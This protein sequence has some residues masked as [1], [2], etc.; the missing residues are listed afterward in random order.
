M[1]AATAS[2]HGLSI[3]SE[4]LLAQAAAF[5]QQLQQDKAVR[6]ASEDAEQEQRRVQIREA[7]ISKQAAAAAEKEAAARIAAQAQAQR[8][9]SA[10]IGTGTGTGTAGGAT[11]AGAGAGARTGN[12]DDDDGEDEGESDNLDSERALEEAAT[13]AEKATPRKLARRKSKRYSFV[14]QTQ[15]ASRADLRKV[16]YNYGGGGKGGL[17]SGSGLGLMSASESHDSHDGGG[18]ASPSGAAS[19]SSTT[20]VDLNV[21]DAAGGGGGGGGGFINAM[22]FSSIWRLITE[23]K[24]NLFKE[25]QMFKRFDRGQEG[26]L[27]E[28]DFVE[29]WCQLAATGAGGYSGEHLLRRITALAADVT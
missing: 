18:T 19:P 27:R 6:L 29:G 8:E 9:A 25:M 20:G 15:Q 21:N 13:A 14:N 3:S 1:Q 26:I 12:A 24:G 16:F 11:G 4:P 5:I 10:N 23:E 22:Q 28:D 7:Q 17:G 2:G